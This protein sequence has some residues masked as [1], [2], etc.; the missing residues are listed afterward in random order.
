[1]EGGTGNDTY[2]VESLDDSVYEQENEGR[3][4]VQ[5]SVPFTLGDNIEDLI[6]VGTARGGD[7]ILFDN[8]I[9]GNDVLNN[10]FGEEGIVVLNGGG[11]FDFVDGGAGNDKLN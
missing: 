4:L 8:T 10:L 5:S 2:I 7:G 11:G 3:D 9:T 6:L 1:M